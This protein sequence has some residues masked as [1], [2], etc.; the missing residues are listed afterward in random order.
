MKK[1]KSCGAIVFNKENQVLVVEMK[2]GH[3]SFPKG[4]IEA[5]ETE[6][7]TAIREVKEETNIDILIDNKFRR[8]S[9][10]SPYQGV[11]KDVVFFIAKAANNNVVIQQ[12]EIQSAGFYD[13]TFVVNKITFKNDLNIYL[14]ALKYKRL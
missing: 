4:H 1:E 11:T 2:Q 12:E 6:E 3:W 5:N 14:D 10:Y 7:E 13:K 8:I 9:T